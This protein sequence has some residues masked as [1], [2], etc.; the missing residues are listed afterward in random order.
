MDCRLTLHA[1]ETFLQLLK[2]N[3]DQHTMVHL[4]VDDH[5]L[6]RLEGWV[7]ALYTDVPQPY[8][9]MEDGHRVGIDKI[10]AV[11]GIFLPEF[12]EC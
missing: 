7:K 8:V 6:E 10:I 5:G 2:S 1:K 9:E 4:L 11:N 3:H 12:G